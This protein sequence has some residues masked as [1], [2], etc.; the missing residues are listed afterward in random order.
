MFPLKDNLPTD[1]RPIVTIALIAIN[2]FVYLFLQPK[3]GIDIGGQNS[4]DQRRSSTTG[5]S[6][7]S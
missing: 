3:S 6:P 7:T 4:L 2:V 5:R 1:R